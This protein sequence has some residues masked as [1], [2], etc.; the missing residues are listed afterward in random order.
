[1]IQMGL[2]VQPPKNVDFPEVRFEEVPCWLNAAIDPIS[3]NPVSRGLSG[4]YFR[5][6]LLACLARIAGVAD[7][8][9]CLRIERP[10]GGI[11]LKDK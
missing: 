9:S 3:S 2:N 11:M 1:M 4:L 10:D 7:S 6:V 8:D 5:A